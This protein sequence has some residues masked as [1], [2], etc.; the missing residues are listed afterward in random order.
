MQAQFWQSLKHLLPNGF[1]WP[2]HEDS[3]QQRWLA[4]V[5]ASLAELHAF[6]LSTAA[7][8]LPHRTCSR[9]E[10]WEASLSLPDSCTADITDPVERQSLMLM[11]L[12]GFE[13]AYPDSSPAALGSIAS[14]C[15]ALG[16]VVTVWYDQEFRV[17]RDGVCD[18]LGSTG[19]LFVS[20]ASMC[21]PMRVEA[22][23]AEHRLVECTKSPE[24]LLCVLGRIVPARFA[25]NLLVDG[26]LVLP[27]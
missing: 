21:E 16:F 11:R 24:S 18:R 2:R 19:D 25:I 5:A 3:V 13:L 20:M 4:G 8:W 9:T 27:C 1:A 15:L 10:E 12:R 17:E 22:D 26:E 14:I 23:G 7:Q 6:C